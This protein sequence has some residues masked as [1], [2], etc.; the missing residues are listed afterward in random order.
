MGSGAVLPL[1]RNPATVSVSEQGPISGFPVAVFDNYWGATLSFTLSLGRRGVPLHLY[2]P[3]AG[4]W[5]RYCTRRFSCPSVADTER[6]LP[7]LRERVRSGEIQ[8]VAPTTDLIAYYLSLLRSEFTPEVQRTIAPLEELENCLIKTRFSQA[9]ARAGQAVP[10]TASPDDP[11]AGVAAAER[12]GFPLVIKPKSHLVVGPA[13]RGQV[14]STVQELRSRYRPYAVAPGQEVLAR[15]YPELRWPLLQEYVPTARNRVFSVSGFRDADTGFIATSLSYKRAQSPPDTGT[16]TSQVSHTD[17]DILQAGL[18]TA[19]NLLSRG[20]FE[21]ELLVS[22]STL[23][24]IDL[25]PRAFGFLS[26]DMALGN[27]LPWL[28]FQSTLGMVVPQPASPD[29]RVIESRQSIPYQL[30][31][32]V[33]LLL[34]AGAAGEEGNEGNSSPKVAQI[35]SMVGSWRDPVPHAIANLRLLRHPRA[36]VGPHVRVARREHRA[37]RDGTQKEAS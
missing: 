37:L 26:L 24:A 2:G 14:V 16:S 3:G 35:V 20:I 22:G 19:G 9:C 13:E 1:A 6:F 17:P 4:R 36:L 31:R 18:Q 11:E 8:R 7:W 29:P 21:L 10:V 25:N 32:C 12:I 5:S 27:D 23:L 34:G 15:R 28:W 33:R 30:N